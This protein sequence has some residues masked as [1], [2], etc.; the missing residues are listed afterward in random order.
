VT[1]GRICN[2]LDTLRATFGHNA[3]VSE[4][5]TGIE[6]IAKSSEES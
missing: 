5:L 6:A 3:L 2:V 4:I 1:I